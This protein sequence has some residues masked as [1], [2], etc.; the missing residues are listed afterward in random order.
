MKILEWVFNLISSV[1]NLWDISGDELFDQHRAYE[2][3]ILV[4]TV[5]TVFL[6]IAAIL[7]T[8]TIEVPPSEGAKF[9]T[10]TI[11]RCIG[12]VAL[13][14]GVFS[15]IASVW[16]VVELLYFRYKY[17]ISDNEY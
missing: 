3:M 9:F 10:Y 2:R 7:V 16:N 12:L 4:Y 8:P 13:V 5:T 14:F 15:L 6:V 11:Y 17:G 1:A